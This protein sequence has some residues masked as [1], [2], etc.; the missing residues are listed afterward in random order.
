MKI[1]IIGYSGAGKSTLAKILGKHYNIPLLHLDSVNFK[2]GWETRN[3]QEFDSIVND[4]I[5]SN[6][7]WIIDGNY[8]KVAK[9][10][11]TDC[12]QLIF[13]NYN[14]FTCLKNVI[15]RYKKYK[16]KSRPDMAF[17]CD[18][19][20]DFAFIMWVLFKGRSK[21]RKLRLANYAINHPNSLVFKNQKELNNY[22][23]NNKIIT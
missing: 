22:L 6:S 1:V 21:N 19:K 17:G 12:D 15:K 23:K 16:G 10:R 20:I 5:N 13:L 14:R 7:S 4:F 18:E 3:I 9:N 11:F 8:H 2:P